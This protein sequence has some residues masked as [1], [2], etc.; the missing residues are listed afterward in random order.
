MTT[1]EKASNQERWFISDNYSRTGNYVICRMIDNDEGEKI[2]QTLFTVGDIHRAILASL[3]PEMC[4]ALAEIECD[5]EHTH[6]IR[7][8]KGC[9][10]CYIRTKLKSILAKATR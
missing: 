6:G 10:F 3:A 5:L 2:E 1:K 9:K 7:G 8:I 4:E